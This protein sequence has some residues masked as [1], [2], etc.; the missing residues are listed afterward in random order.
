[1]GNLSLNFYLIFFHIIL[2]LHSSYVDIEKLILLF[3]GQMT[4]VI[5][6]MKIF[7]IFY[8]LIKFSLP[9]YIDGNFFNWN[10]LSV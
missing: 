2:F 9:E 1:M 5:Y 8:F 3:L 7:Y 6:P 4:Q 10:F